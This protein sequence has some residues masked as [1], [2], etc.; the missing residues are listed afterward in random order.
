MLLDE[1]RM[2]SSNLKEKCHG[3]VDV[4]GHWQQLA[5][6]TEWRQDNLVSGSENAR[7]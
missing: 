3:K 6:V 5:K 7:H 4:A 2:L 1:I